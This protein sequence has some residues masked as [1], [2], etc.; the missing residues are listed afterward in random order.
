MSTR[1]RTCPFCGYDKCDAEFIDIGVGEQQTC[2]YG[3]NNCL[4]FQLSPYREDE[5]EVLDADE[6]RCGW[7]KGTLL[8]EILRMDVIVKGRK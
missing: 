7:R 2:P 1:Y 5:N 6:R 8:A 4:S 3:C